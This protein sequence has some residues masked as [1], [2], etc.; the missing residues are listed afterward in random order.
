MAAILAE[1]RGSAGLFGQEQDWVPRIEYGIAVLFIE[2]S[3]SPTITHMRKL[4]VPLAALASLLLAIVVAAAARG[5]WVEAR[6]PNFIVVSNAG[7]GQARKVAIQFEQIRSLFRDSLPY[8]KRSSSPV[9]TILAV[10][11]EDSL[12][13]LL[14]EFWAQ[15][16]HTHPGGIFINRYNQF[17][18]A[19][20]ISA[21]GDNAYEAVYHEYYHSVTMPYFP[22]LP[23]WVSEGLADFY[24]NS[25]I[26]DKTADLGMP[27]GDLIEELRTTP[28]I[29]LSTLLKV[30]HSSPY[31]NEQNKVSIFYAESWALTHYLMLGDNRA[32]N[33]AFG[34]YLNALS[35]G[36]SQDEAAAKA[37]GDLGKLQDDLKRYIGR[38]SFPAIQVPAPAK[39]LDSDLTVRTLSDANVDAYHGGFLALHDQF[40]QAEPL[41]KEAAQLDPKLAL[42]QRNLALMHYFREERTDALASLSAAIALEEQDADLR[43]LRA[44]LT[45]DDVSQSDPQ[46]QEDLQRALASKPDF[47]AANCLLAVFLAAKNEKLPE[48]LGFAQK[49][50]SLEPGNA[51]FQL[52]LAQV[53]VRAQRYNDAEAWGRRAR[54]NATDD[55]VR[56]QAEQFLYYVKQARDYDAQVRQ[57]QQ[58][59]AARASAS[60]SETP[61]VEISVQRIPDTSVDTSVPILKHRGPDDSVEGVVTQVRCNGDA[62]EITVKLG[63]ASAPLLFRAKNRNRID[64]TSDIHTVRGDIEP[65]SELKGHTAKIVFTT[66]ESKAFHGELAHI[67][68]TK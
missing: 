2:T 29:P 32:H 4:I 18:V 67:E 19:V 56:T 23:T 48:A 11:D 58:E 6:S 44:E 17:Q 24:G 64:Y 5:R 52:A 9:I 8:V 42:A 51:S 65:C 13:E 53:L 66:A 7:E 45:F 31:Y 40:Q 12:R 63:A 21:H 1:N 37:F 54:A 14:P 57:M 28:L 50:V 62:M 59:A 20:N 46:I 35:Q 61:S 26:S 38:F 36:A 60:Q 22:G 68:V 10:K 47:A 49:A 39:L 33:P 55:R 41:L 30:D 15:K 25:I 3:T 34:V 27:N 43:Y 16:G